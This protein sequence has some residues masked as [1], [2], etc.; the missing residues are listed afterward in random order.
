DAF[1]RYLRKE[2]SDPE[3]RELLVASFFRLAIR[4]GRGAVVDWTPVKRGADQVLQ[5]WQGLDPDARWRLEL[6]RAVA[7]RHESNGGDPPLPSRSLM[8]LLPMPIRVAV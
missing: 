2:G 4:D 3:R 6:A 7:A 1:E 5:E 8:Q